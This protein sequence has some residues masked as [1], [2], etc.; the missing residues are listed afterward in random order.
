[1]RTIQSVYRDPLELIWT[2]A[3]RKFGMTIER[4]P[5]VFAS[6]DGSGVLKI[7]VPETL[8]A[9]DSL[10]QMIFHEVCHALVEGPAAIHKP[11]WGLQID[12]PA[13]RVREHACLR[14]Q[15]AL[16]GQFGLRELLA[17]TTNFRKYYDALPDNPLH[18]DNDPA[19]AIARRG[20]ND[21]K[22]GAWAT[23]LEDALRMTS[24]IA[25][26]VAAVAPAN[27]LWGQAN[28]SR[29]HKNR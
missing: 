7:G 8:D 15:A 27:S 10:A 2:E 22:T 24:Q 13:H 18:G 9:D 12:N 21:A 11:D 4:D 17:A 26:A 29:E 19:A 14:L 28:I 5:A 6:W 23:P 20:W 1:M 25:A 3:A 16:A